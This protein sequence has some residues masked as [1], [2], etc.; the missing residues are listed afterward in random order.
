LTHLIVYVHNLLVGVVNFSPEIIEVVKLVIQ[1]IQ[2]VVILKQGLGLADL[3]GG[4]FWLSHRVA[5]LLLF[6]Y[7]GIWRPAT[8]KCVLSL[9]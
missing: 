3:C 9:K 6:D 5:G 1:E 8:T 2:F 4:H 7:S